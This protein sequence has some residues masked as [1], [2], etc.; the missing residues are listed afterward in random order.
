[1]IFNPSDSKVFKEADRLYEEMI[2]GSHALAGEPLKRWQ[3]VLEEAMKNFSV[4]IFVRDSKGNLE[5]GKNGK[6]KINWN[7]LILL[8]AR[9]IALVRLYDTI[10]TKKSSVT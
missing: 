5:L 9:L 1:M 6:P 10:G 4:K 2:M 3:F 8:V 7:E